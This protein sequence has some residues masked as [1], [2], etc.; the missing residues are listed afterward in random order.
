VRASQGLVTSVGI[1][2]IIESFWGR[3]SPKGVLR[4]AP[5]REAA[6]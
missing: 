5:S 2:P 1:R 3:S 6:Q 4:E